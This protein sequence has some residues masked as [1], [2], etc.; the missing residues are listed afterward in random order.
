MLGPVR[1]IRATRRAPRGAEAPVRRGGGRVRR[2][3][4]SIGERIS[5]GSIRLPAAF[6]TASSVCVLSAH[7][8]SSGEHFPRISEKFWSF[9]RIGTRSRKSFASHARSSARSPRASHA[10]EHE[11]SR[12]NGSVARSS[13]ILPDEAHRGKMGRR[14]TTVRDRASRTRKRESRSRSRI[15]Y[16]RVKFAR[17]SSVI[18]RPDLFRSSSATRRTSV[19]DEGSRPQRSNF[20]ERATRQSNLHPVTASLFALVG[21]G[22]FTLFRDP[23]PWV[24]R[25]DAL[26]D[27]AARAWSATD[28]FSSRPRR[29]LFRPNTDAQRSL[30]ARRRS[31]CSGT[32]SSATAVAI[33]IRPFPGTTLPRARAQVA[34]VLPVQRTQFALPSP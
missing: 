20:F 15:A 13:C 24:A 30:C 29:R 19:R 33:L 9:S 31:S 32:S 16:R 23:A 7:G 10:R 21:I 5:G 1:K 8:P 34:G 27:A 14:S 25:A 17:R 28:V 6:C 4:R 11:P 26:R 18:C 12:R 3:P 2:W 22:R